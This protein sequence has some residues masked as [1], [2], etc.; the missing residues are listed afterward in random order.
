KQLD[1][2]VK[3]VRDAA[4][5]FQT[6]AEQLKQKQPMNETRAR[7]LYEAAWAHRSLAALEVETAR[8]K[9]QQE[10]WQKR[11]DEALK[12][13]PPGQQPPAVPMPVVELKDVPVQPSETAARAQYQALIDAFPD[14]AINADALFELA[15]LMSER[16]EHDNAIK[17]LRAALDKE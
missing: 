5:Y 4:L 12:R 6:Q 1:D 14:L 16:A 11:R 13:T 15:E 10:L 7:M 2:G 17:M 3:E 9:V 8:A